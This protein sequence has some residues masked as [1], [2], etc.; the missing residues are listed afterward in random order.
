MEKLSVQGISFIVSVVLARILCPDDYGI[1]ALILVFINVSNVIIDGGLNVALIQKKDATQ[2][3]FSTIFWICLGMSFVLYIFLYVAA[4][5]IAAFYEDANLTSAI[6]VLS[7]SLFPYALNSIQRAY[8]SRGM[9]FKKLFVSN[10]WATV[11][12]GLLGIALAKCGFKYWALIWFTIAQTTLLAIV[13]WYTVKWRPS[14]TFSRHS[15]VTLFGYGWKIFLSSLS[16]TIFVNVR[17][18]LLG[19][20]YTRAALAYFE[21]GKQLPA[22]VMENIN[23]SVQTVLFPALSQEQDNKDRVAALMSRSISTCNFFILP[24][25]MWAIVCADEIICLLLT[26]KWI[27]T[28]PYIQ[29]FCVA[30]M[31]MP[32]QVGNIEVI[33]SLGRSD[34]ILKIS[35]LKIV[36]DI[37]ILVMA[38]SYGPLVIAASVILFNFICIFINLLPVARLLNQSISHQLRDFLPELSASLVMGGLAYGAGTLVSGDVLS[39]VVKSLVALL[40]YFAICGIFRISSFLYIKNLL[41]QRG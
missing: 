7:L 23:T 28:V 14:F 27:E 3:D 10:L 33:K 40:S 1:V 2:E 6:R 32:I 41:L 12:S 20:I 16:A 15:F 29:V 9:L 5:N 21:R 17:G 36:L 35:L 11:F 38:F 39:L 34:I 37:A 8:I 18:M 31:L 24:V 26:E 25:M 4:P 30:Y 22:L 19:T 13:M